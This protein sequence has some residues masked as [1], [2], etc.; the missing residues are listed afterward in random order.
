METPRALTA[1]VAMACCVLSAPAFAQDDDF[2]L[3]NAPTT[4]AAPPPTHNA[5]PMLPMPS[6]SQ[7]APPY[8]NEIVVGGGWQSG[9]AQRYGR[10][11]GLGSPGAIGIG[12]FKLHSGDAWDSGGT[13]YL[14]AEAMDLGITGRSGTLKFGEQGKWGVSFSYNG[15][16]NYYSS[17]FHTIWNTN[18]TLANGIAPGSV[19]NA[20]TIASKLN[21]MDIST[22]RDI[23]SAGG[24]MQYGDWLIQVNLRH[25][26]KEGFK[27]NSLAILGAPS[28]IA[29]NGNVTTSGLGYFAEPINYDTDRYDVTGQYSQG[30]FQALLGYTFNNFTDNLASDNL[31]NPFQFLNTASVTGVAAGAA[32]GSAKITSDYSLPPSSSA[33][34]LKGQFGYNFS[35]TTRWTGNVQLG[36]MLQ[37]SGF[38][39]G[40]GN[41]NIASVAPPTSSL[42]GAIQTTHA[43][44]AL[45]TVP[46]TNAD[47][48]LSYTLDDRRNQ[49]PRSAY[50]NQFYQDAYSA[51]AITV[52]NLPLSYQHQQATADFG[53]RLTPSTK[54]MVGYNYDTTVRNDSATGQVNQNAVNAKV[55]TNFGNDVF[56]NIALLHEDREA[57]NYNRNA[58][59]VALGQS[60]LNE[61]A[62]FVNYYEA[63]RKRE[64][65]KGTIDFPIGP[66][67]TATVMGAADYDRYPNSALGLRNNN[68]FSIGPDFTYQ[69]ASNLSA[70]GYYTYQ[71]IFFDQANAV[72]NA[73]CNGNGTTLTVGAAPCQNNGTW[74]GRN[75]DSTHTAGLSLDW[76]PMEALKI[77]ADYTFSYGRNAYSIANGGIFS[78]VAAGTAALQVAPIPDV[79]SMLNSVSLRAEYQILPNASLWLAYN[80]ERFDAKD[81]ATQVGAA[82][83]SNALFSGDV[84]PSYNVHQVLAAVRVRW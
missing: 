28:P 25:E 80:Y 41:A 15:I 54:L 4:A 11:T 48:R 38:V 10:F 22:Q 64:E 63:S 42:A 81:Y 35:P 44:T 66:K 26:H 71:M 17:Q 39:P 9:T 16:P 84:G 37:N 56:G 7:P 13:F 74:V 77:S 19:T 20:T 30:K 67:M 49:T 78:F 32:A 18:G 21:V 12:A 14:D 23:F 34:Q 75:M 3:S 27:E 46:W 69:F 76:Q 2:D 83:F 58:A 62:G 1:A 73:A 59:W 57:G 47:L 55:R 40:S 60:T 52:Y 53:Y 82:Q 36:M 72:S 6:V 50:V 8:S 45:T 68:N 43:N 5:I 33:H 29:N 65:V 70:H 24:K 31:T 61:F 51:S 79:T